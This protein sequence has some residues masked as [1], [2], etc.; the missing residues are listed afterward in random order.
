MHIYIY[1][2]CEGAQFQLRGSPSFFCCFCLLL[3]FFFFFPKTLPTAEGSISRAAREPWAR[4]ARK[5]KNDA[6]AEGS[7]A[8]IEVSG[9]LRSSFNASLRHFRKAFREKRGLA[10]VSFAVLRGRKKK[11][12][13][14][15]SPRF[16]RKNPF[17]KCAKK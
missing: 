6:R 16:H 17:R 12:I 13:L 11:H 14:P 1:M 7:L 8:A 5:P 3:F 9:P 2:S 10:P 4:A 15:K